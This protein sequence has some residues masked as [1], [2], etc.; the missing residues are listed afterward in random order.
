MVAE[1]A[2]EKNRRP[3][4]SMFT[5][6]ALQIVAPLIRRE[7]AR[8]W[9]EREDGRDAHHVDTDSGFQLLS[10]LQKR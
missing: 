6:I 7:L 9:A 8:I 3:E 4:M 1:A 10:E 2:R 5:R